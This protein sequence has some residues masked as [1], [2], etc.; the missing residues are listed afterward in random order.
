MAETAKPTSVLLEVPAAQRHRIISG[1]RWTVWL[2]ILAIPFSY[3]TTIVLART[4]PEAIGTY[5]LLGV[6]IALSLGI[7]Y[8]G[9]DAVAI[10]FI[11]ELEPDKRLSFLVSYFAVIC[12]AVLPWI[13]VGAI[14]PQALQHV[15]GTEASPRFELLLL[16]LS[17]VAM[18][19]SLV[20][21]A[22]KAVLEIGWAQLIYRL[23]TITSFLIYVALFLFSRP[24]L[25]QYYPVVIWGTYLTVSLA[26]A[27]A[28][29]VYLSRVSGWHI[30]SLSLRFFLPRG[31][32][33][34]TLSLQQLSA[35]SF[36]AG[37]LDVLLLLN[38]AGLA[39]LG[40]Y[41]AVITIAEAIRLISNYFIGTLLPSLTNTLADGNKAGAADA[42]HTH[43]RIL[44][45]VSAASTCGLILLARPITALLGPKYAGLSTLIV[46]VAL[47][48][49]ICTPGGVGG[50]LLSAI[51]KQQRAVYVS[52]VQIGVYVL[53]FASLWPK[54]RLTGAVLA[55]GFA[56]V[57]SNWALL[58]VARLSSPFPFSLLRDYVAFVL[59]AAASAVLARSTT[60]GI[61]SG[62]AAWSAA[63]VLFLV[64]ARYHW[65]ECKSL[66]HCFL[67]LSQT[68]PPASDSD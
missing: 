38:F 10:K 4:S 31:F 6:Y 29:F 68:G 61:T 12:I 22:L 37:R 5:G 2:S 60:L 45:F 23:A 21:A 40:K 51:G 18:V 54:Y 27:I 7:C 33:P 34:Y 9:G 43:M 20:S 66:L 17:P 56:W 19:A 42:F 36:F 32:W 24:T 50:T 41:V 64:V 30:R 44:F 58:G 65:A 39:L 15:F 14:W 28:G 55:Y 16:A 26:A 47:L 57:I 67:P 63:V 25:A 8:L 53:L 59:T 1:M 52:A 62:L 13:I 48:V 35:L 11:P 46:L 3:G 49:G